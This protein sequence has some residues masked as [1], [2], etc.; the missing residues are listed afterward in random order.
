MYSS[1]F[2]FGIFWSQWHKRL[3]AI[4]FLSSKSQ[5][6]TLQ[7]LIWLQEILPCNF[8][9]S[10]LLK[11][12]YNVLKN[13]KKIGKNTFRKK[14]KI[15]KQHCFSCIAFRI[16]LYAM[17]VIL[18]HKMWAGKNK[19]CSSRLTVTKRNCWRKQLRNPQHPLI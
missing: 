3:A 6:E 18:T 8:T 16:I 5:V 11:V 14:K 2:L 17:K 13:K 10:G 15:L 19:W 7:I 9:G 1:K 4:T 12:Y